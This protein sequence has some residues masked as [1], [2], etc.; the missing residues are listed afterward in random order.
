MHPAFVSLAPVND[1]E[2]NWPSDLDRDWKRTTWTGS[3]HDTHSLLIAFVPFFLFLLSVFVLFFFSCWWYHMR[4][5]QGAWC[6]LRRIFF[7]WQKYNFLFWLVVSTHVEWGWLR[8]SLFCAWRNIPLRKKMSVVRSYLR[9]ANWKTGE[10]F[11]KKKRIRNSRRRLVFL[12]GT[13]I[14]HMQMRRLTSTVTLFRL[15]KRRA[16]QR[17]FA[18][19]S[20]SASTKRIDPICISDENEYQWSYR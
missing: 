5:I 11:E 15:D 17:D 10:N 20:S 12:D 14:H 13:H 1:K 7:V 18:R 6:G 3:H 2:T 9:R 19:C 16:H 4:W 8:Y